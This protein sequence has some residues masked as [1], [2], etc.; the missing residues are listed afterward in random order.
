MAHSPP[1]KLPLTV[2]II[3]LN[4]ASQIGE[5]L[6]SCAFADEV[7]VV[8]SGSSDDT[9]AIV[10]RHGGRFVHNDWP[11]F[12]RQKQFAVQQARNEWVLCLDVDERVTERL[13]ASI[14]EAFASR[15]YQAWRMARRNRF[16]GTWLAHGE[17][18]PDWSLRLFHRAHAS[19]SNDEVHE[20]VLT[21]AEVGRL[22][23]DLLHDSADDI[24]TYLAKQNRYTTL[25]AKALFDQ[26]V[27][28]SAWRLF[29]S[30]FVRFVKFYIVKLGFL[31]GGPG[32]AHV[33]I[34]C[35]NTFH[36]YLKLIEL[37]RAAK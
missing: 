28:T 4:A 14:R 35:N 24:A 5:C 32:F 1:G 37:Q 29:L 15:R 16:L 2:A 25:H 23:G 31:D 22:E 33:V 36:K 11:G 19:W 3:A 9:Q 30:P 7:L 26:G 12:G 8:D 21:T 10:E 27:R 18:Y 13:Q 6:A 34:G 17:G 20:A